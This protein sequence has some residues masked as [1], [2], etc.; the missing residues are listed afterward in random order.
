MKR[1][2]VTTIMSLAMLLT[3]SAQALRPFHLR[4][5]YT[6]IDSL[7]L[8][9]AQTNNLSGGDY[10]IDL[11]RKCKIVLAYNADRSKTIILNIRGGY[12]FVR[13]MEYNVSDS[14]ER[15]VLYYKDDHLYCG[16]IYDKR[17]KAGK[18]FEAINQDEKE[19]LVERIPFLKRIPTFTNNKADD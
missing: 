6:Q 2:I 4:E 13:H 12:N 11:P 19:R 5:V 3:V 1:L 10:I 14:E 8:E 17:I 7:V 15:T 18:Y 9:H 16:Y